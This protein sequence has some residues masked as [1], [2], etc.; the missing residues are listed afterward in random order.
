MQSNSK[1]TLPMAAI[2]TSMDLCNEN[3][4]NKSTLDRMREE[5]RCYLEQTAELKMENEELRKHVQLLQKKIKKYEQSDL[6][7]TL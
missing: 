5:I 1:I 4:K 6:Q 7:E 2:L 3:E